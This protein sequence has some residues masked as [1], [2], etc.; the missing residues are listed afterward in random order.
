MIVVFS[1]SNLDLIVVADQ[2]YPILDLNCK[3]YGLLLRAL[4]LS[5][6]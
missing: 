1:K 6:L 4:T 5:A 2:V 3:S